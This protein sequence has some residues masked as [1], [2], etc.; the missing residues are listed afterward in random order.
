MIPILYEA[1]ETAFISNGICRLRDIIECVV[2]EERNSIYELNFRYPVTGA[3]F[4][5]IQC[6]RIIAVRHDDTDDV[7]P[8]DIIS[9]SKPIN[10]IVSFHAV[11]I[12]YRLR[13]CVVEDENVNSLTA[14]LTALATAT[15]ANGFTYEADFT[16]N[17]YAGAFD[18][19]P[20]TVRQL[21]GGVEGSILDTYGGEYEWDKFKVVLHRAR[22]STVD[23]QIRYGLNMVDYNEDL[24]YSETY[25]SAVPY[26]IGD[27]GNGGE[28]SVVGNKVNSGLVPYNGID[29]CVPL[30]LSEKFET[31]PT[32]AELETYALNKMTSQ[33]VNTPQQSIQ[34][35]F[36]RLNDYDEY[37]SVAPLL[38]CKL[39]D[40]IEVIFPDYQTTA[41][42]KIVRTEYDVLRE[43]FSSMELGTLSTTLAEAL[44]VNGNGG[45]T[46]GGGGGGG[47]TDYNDLS[48]KPSINNVTL[49]GN[50]TS[51]AL[52]IHE[53]P[54]GGSTGQVLKKNSGT[55]YDVSWGSAGAGTV[56]DVK[57]D[58]TSVVTSN[59]ANIA[60]ATTSASGAM[61]ATD[62]TKL[63][64]IAS[65]AEANVLEGVQ[66]NGSD[67]TI[68]SKKVNIPVMTGATTSSAGKVG[69]VPAPAS[70]TSGQYKVLLD[71]GA[72]HTVT[73]QNLNG[74]TSWY[75]IIN[76]DEDNYIQ[77]SIPLASS[78][79]AGLV[80]ASERLKITNLYENIYPPGAIFET[81]DSAYDPN[82]TFGYYWA[83]LGQL[84]DS[85]SVYL[86]TSD[87][88]FLYAD[89]PSIVRTYK[90]VRIWLPK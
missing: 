6:G 5:E 56:I 26:W 12:S 49:S 4:E 62:K 15:P 14:A 72:W 34:V 75:G 13:G 53:I 81:T 83:M 31:E 64:G 61:S 22:G 29:K 42:F 77:F 39:C 17:G 46:S 28:T 68:T 48:N 90:W 1:N 89:E 38:Q 60:N 43:R 9:Y 19:T 10:G 33:K 25:T 51:S 3:N 85:D 59:V 82:T 52:G 11:H 30:D 2:V 27:D 35:D 23:F 69:L 86:E 37:S 76:I 45:G 47:T 73:S 79:T 8:F 55:D 80:T 7:Q 71:D 87:G 18:G 44:G 58:G 32:T 78:S 41:Y 40:S 54:S 57:V 50:K 70:M 74:G 20:K 24:D 84:M 65:G 16:A 63:D 21:L 36:I 67:L 66:L 88:G